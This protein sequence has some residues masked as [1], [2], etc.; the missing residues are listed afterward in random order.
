M[1]YDCPI[2][3]KPMEPDSMSA[4]TIAEVTR[5]ESHHWVWGPH[6]VQVA[7]C[8]RRLPFSHRIGVDDFAS[9]AER[10]PGNRPETARLLGP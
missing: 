9:T 10:V 6:P 2:C 7:P 5:G 1:M 4:T 8:R 3:S